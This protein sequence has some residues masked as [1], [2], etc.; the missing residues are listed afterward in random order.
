MTKTKETSRLCTFVGGS[1]DGQRLRYEDSVG[2]IITPKQELYIRKGTALF[3]FDHV[4]D[5][6]T[7]P[8]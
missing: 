1:K 2:A 7:I 5:N 4:L 6:D 8:E 3:V